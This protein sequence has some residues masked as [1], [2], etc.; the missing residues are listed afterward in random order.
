MLGYQVPSLMVL[1]G[2][3]SLSEPSSHARGPLADETADPRLTRAWALL[4]AAAHTARNEALPARARFGLDREGRLRR[5]APGG[6]AAVLEW[7]SGAGWAVL[8]PAPTAELAALYDLYLPICSATSAAPLT[9]AHLG[10]SLDGYI[11]TGT[12]DSYY[13]TGAQNIV[14]LHRMRAL[15]DAVIVGAATVSDDDPRLTARLAGGP[16][17]VRVVLDPTRRLAE[18]RAVFSDRRAPTLLVCDE[19]LVGAGPAV[20]GAAEVLGVACRSGRLD[21]AAVVARLHAR[22]LNALF[23]EGGGRTVSGFLESGLLDR[24]QIAVAPLV[25]GQG[26]PGVRL[27]ASERIAECLRPAHRTFAMG[28]D[29]LFDCDLRRPPNPERRGGTAPDAAGPRGLRRID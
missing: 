6:E 11:A 16:S 24:L 18:T 8:E 14:H 9:V 27:P 29:V 20:L 28:A 17:P 5:E 23:V 1:S 2:E 15:S 13:V 3:P 12:G 25:M 4:L 7:R 26:R 10:Q 19:R 21:L 22:G